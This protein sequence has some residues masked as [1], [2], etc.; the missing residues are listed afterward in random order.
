MLQQ[1]IYRNI[2]NLWALEM[3]DRIV[4]KIFFESTLAFDCYVHK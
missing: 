1:A 2:S 3:S 4:P